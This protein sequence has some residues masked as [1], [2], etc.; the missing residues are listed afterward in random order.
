MLIRTITNKRVLWLVGAVLLLLA[1]AET[2]SRQATTNFHV[3]SLA[4]V[5]QAFVSD[6]N[7][8][9]IDQ[10]TATA[11][12]MQK[13]KELR[14]DVVGLHVAAAHHTSGLLE[15]QDSKGHVIYRSSNGTDAWVLEL[16]APAQLG[17]N[18]VSGAAVVD[19]I[20]GKL[21]SLSVLLSNT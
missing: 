18:S 9:D 19:T 8:G 17:F 15:V 13:A 2:G 4:I 11:K 3:G 7:H 16:S 14:P 10:E 12:A 1:L 5:T 21:D 6:T 20:T